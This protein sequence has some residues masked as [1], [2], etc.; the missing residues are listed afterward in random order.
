M[1]VLRRAA[2]NVRA[3]FET[4]EWRSCRPACMRRSCSSEYD[5]PTA[6]VIYWN[7]GSRSPAARCEPDL[8]LALFSRARYREL[9]TARTAIERDS[10]IAVQVAV[11]YLGASVVGNSHVE[12]MPPE[13]V[14]MKPKATPVTRL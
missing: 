2:A 7:E 12:R 3:M 6:H 8:A 5:V 9:T 1:V 13:F 11:L 10:P 4:S 14:E